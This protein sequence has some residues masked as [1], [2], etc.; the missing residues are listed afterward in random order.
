MS[1]SSSTCK[2]ITMGFNHNFITKQITYQS[3]KQTLNICTCCGFSSTKL[4]INDDHFHTWDVY[5]GMNK[6]NFILRCGN[7]TCKERI[8][9][10]S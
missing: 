9:F 6:D 7:F 4:L 1:S 10:K 5:L 3:Y 2:L 8:E